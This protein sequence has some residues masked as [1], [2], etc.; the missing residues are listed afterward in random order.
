MSQI[1]PGIEIRRIS[2]HKTSFR[3]LLDLISRKNFPEIAIYGLVSF[4]LLKAGQFINF[5]MGVL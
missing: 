1:L 5:V 2:N 3:E 4:G